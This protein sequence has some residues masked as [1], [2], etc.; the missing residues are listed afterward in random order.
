M[1]SAIQI[2]RND[3]IFFSYEKKKEKY[4]TLQLGTIFVSPN[5]SLSVNFP[6]L[7]KPHCTA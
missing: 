4:S 7:S 5:K 3:V 1:L 6:Q 2:A